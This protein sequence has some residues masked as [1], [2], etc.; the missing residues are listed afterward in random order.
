MEVEIVVQGV[1]IDLAA[2]AGMQR[3]RLGRRG[4]ISVRPTCW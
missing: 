3:Q 1:R 2:V 4:K